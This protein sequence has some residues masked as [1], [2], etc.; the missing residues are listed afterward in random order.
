MTLC[1]L[2]AAIILSLTSAACAFYSAHLFLFTTFWSYK[3]YYFSF[4]PTFCKIYLPMNQTIETIKIKLDIYQKSNI[5]LAYQLLSQI[6]SL[7]K[8]RQ[9]GKYELSNYALNVIQYLG[10]RLLFSFK[11]NS[12]DITLEM[13]NAMKGFL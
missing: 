1:F 12:A 10:I 5:T 9:F 7:M 3:I 4:D 11:D 13:N 8:M 6:W 2:K